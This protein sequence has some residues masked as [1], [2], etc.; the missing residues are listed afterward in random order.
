MLQKNMSTHT[1]RR[2]KMRAALLGALIIWPVLAGDSD[3]AN[4]AI[5]LRWIKE[6]ALTDAATSIDINFFETIDA[7]L[8]QKLF[9]LIGRK[10]ARGVPVDR[11]SEWFIISYP[12]GMNTIKSEVR[13]QA[14]ETGR[15]VP[16]GHR[17]APDPNQP[18]NTATVFARSIDPNVRTPNAVYTTLLQVN[19]A[20]NRSTFVTATV[21]YIYDGRKF[22]FKRIRL[23]P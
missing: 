2:M 10:H 1:F 20:T 16:V 9:N 13:H 18:H 5:N 6:S 21:L 4:W 14:T 3:K 23:Q 7:E 12:P 11:I 17:Y 22:R 19:E 8:G 15:L